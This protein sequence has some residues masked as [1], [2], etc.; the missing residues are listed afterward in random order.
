M[1]AV[2][3]CYITYPAPANFLCFSVVFLLLLLLLFPCKGLSVFPSPLL[4]YLPCFLFSPV[5][6][7]VCL[8]VLREGCQGEAC[9]S[10]CSLHVSRCSERGA[11]GRLVC[12]CVVCLLVLREGCQGKACLCVVCLLVLREGC[13]GKASLSVCSLSP[14]AP[15]GVP[16]EGL[17]V[18]V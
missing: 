6:C 10:V 14:G 1:S 4:P 13:Q 7:I 9:L 15:R 17:S 18:F 5:F 12:L 8:L 16:G 3:T 2:R 11:G